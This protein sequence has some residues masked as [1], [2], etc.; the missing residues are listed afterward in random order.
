MLIQ[1]HETR[2][3][4]NADYVSAI[5]VRDELIRQRNGLI[6]DF[7]KIELSLRIKAWTA[8]IEAYE[9]AKKN[10]VPKPTTGHRTDW[11]HD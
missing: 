5:Q 4:T 6:S 1:I 7:Q 11:A 10:P 8:K 3:R 9:E 2:I